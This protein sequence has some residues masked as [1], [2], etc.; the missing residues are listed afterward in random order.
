VQV[1][2]LGDWQDTF[3]N[4]PGRIGVLLWSRDIDEAGRLGADCQAGGSCCEGAVPL[5]AS[6][7]ANT[8]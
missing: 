5:L 6:S 3:D 2:L 8:Y 4:R 7:A 1:D